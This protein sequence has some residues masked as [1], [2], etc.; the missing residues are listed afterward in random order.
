MMFRKEPFF[1]GHDNYDQLVK[2]AK[3]LGTDDLVNYLE[4]Y[5]I[6]LDQQF[7]GILERHSKKPLSKFISKENQTICPQE[8]LDFLEACL[9]YDHSLRILPKESME[10][11]YFQPVVKM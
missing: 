7:D 11:P 1:H 9:L 6:E 8:A 3:I 10:H 2:I 4:K 5:N